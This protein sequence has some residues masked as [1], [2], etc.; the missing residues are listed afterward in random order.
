[1]ALALTGPWIGT[2]AMRLRL[3]ALLF[4]AG[5]VVSLPAVLGPAGLQQ[6]DRGSS[7]GPQVV[8]QYERLP[9]LTRRSVRAGRGTAARGNDYRRYLALWQAGIVREF[10]PW[11]VLPAV[12]GSVLLLVALVLVARPLGP[13]SRLR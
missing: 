2:H 1:V 5:F 9:E 10:G 8:R 4:A 7:D 3:A 11:G 13:R 12:L 6:L